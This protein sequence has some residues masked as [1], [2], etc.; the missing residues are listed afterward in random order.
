MDFEGILTYLG[1]WTA[2]FIIF[3]LL[4]PLLSVLL[5]LFAEFSKTF[6]VF[7][8]WVIFREYLRTID[9]GLKSFM[10]IAI[11][12]MLFLG[13]SWETYMFIK[14]KKG[15]NLEYKI[16]RFRKRKSILVKT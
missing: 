3:F 8:A 10:N 15:K 16:P 11:C 5:K 13:V 14:E 1:F 12:G 6:T 7:A 2:L 9:P 4:S